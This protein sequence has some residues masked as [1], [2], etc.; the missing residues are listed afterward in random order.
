VILRLPLIFRTEAQK[1][2]KEILQN[3]NIYTAKQSIDTN[4]EISN[5]FASG[6]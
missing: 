3:R 5:I 1:P 6:Q 2:T 4:F